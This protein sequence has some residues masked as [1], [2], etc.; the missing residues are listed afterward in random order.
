MTAEELLL[1]IKR[2]AEHV[3][4]FTA[5]LSGGP[6]EESRLL[7]SLEADIE[8]WFADQGKPLYDHEGEHR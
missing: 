5:R 7:C 4:R 3:R 8:E 2:R 1:N 6:T